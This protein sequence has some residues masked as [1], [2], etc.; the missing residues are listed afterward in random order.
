MK[1]IN[2]QDA[3]KVECPHGG[4]ISHRYLL[5]SDNM[6]FTITSTFVPIGTTQHW[7][8]KN[9][10]EACLC[11]S[12]HG[13]LVDIEAGKAYDI[14]PG[15]MYILDNNDEH[16]FKAMSDT[17]LVCAFNPPLKGKEVHQE[18]GSYEL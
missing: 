13:V 18:D 10:L 4:F 6:G 9:H 8:Y 5:E 12:G 17:V 11:I 16:T 15:T 3:L 14:L 7:H 1:V 2:K